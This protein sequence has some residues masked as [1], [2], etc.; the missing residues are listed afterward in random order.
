[1]NKNLFIINIIARSSTLLNFPS[2]KGTFNILYDVSFQ[3]LVSKDSGKNIE[4]LK[5]YLGSTPL[6]F[7]NP[8]IFLWKSNF[9][10]Y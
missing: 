9:S 3:S 1:M 10:P 8:V 5:Y 6:A 7:K 4:K 2:Y